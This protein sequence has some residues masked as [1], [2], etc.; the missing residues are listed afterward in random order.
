[1]R[2]DIDIGID[3]DHVVNIHR[4]VQDST[5]VNENWTV[6]FIVFRSM[7][8]M[9]WGAVVNNQ[10]AWAVSSEKALRVINAMLSTG[11]FRMTTHPPG[12]TTSSG[13]AFIR[14]TTDEKEILPGDDKVLRM[15][16][17]ML[18]SGTDLLSLPELEIGEEVTTP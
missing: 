15:H 6:R 4:Y 16:R 13:S 14:P 18:M 10:L 17:H 3:E 5:Q 1:M 7:G 9:M 11:R 2:E 8:K 12:V